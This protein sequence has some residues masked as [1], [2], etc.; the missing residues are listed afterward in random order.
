M[1][2]SRPQA[3]FEVWHSCLGH[4]NFDVIT[5]LQKLGYLVV[6]ALLPKPGLCSP[7][8]L[9][10]TQRLPFVINKTRALNLLDL[11]HC[12][13]WG[14]SPIASNDNYRYYVIFVDDHSRFSWLYPLKA[15]S[16]FSRVL[17]GFLNMVQ[18]QFSRKI[19][20]FQS[21]GGTEFFNHHVKSIF[22][23]NGTLHRS[24]CPYTLQQNGRAERKH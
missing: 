14:P 4:A 19:K 8:Q 18:T 5:S 11:V 17:V 12:D 10:K 2:H 22:E 16:D 1:S 15:K 7:C 6:N 24:S 23:A 21:D 13:L 3:S 20:I 9:A